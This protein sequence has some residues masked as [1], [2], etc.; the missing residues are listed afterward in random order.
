[1][2]LPN[3]AV[4]QNIKSEEAMKTLSFK[5]LFF[6]VLTGLLFPVQNA[7]SQSR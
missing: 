6:T 4:Q 1:M 2:P 7:L 5:V 3:L